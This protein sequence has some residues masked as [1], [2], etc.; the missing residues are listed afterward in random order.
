VSTHQS[1][2][3]IG[4]Q[5]P[6]RSEASVPPIV[7]E[8]GAAAQFAWDEYFRG[9]I[10][11]DYTR[12]TYMRAVKQ[13]LNWCEIQRFPLSKITPGMV[14]EYLRGLRLATASKK[15]HLA[16]IRAFFDV[17]VQRH[18]IALNPAHSVRTERL[19]IEEGRTPQI[20]FDE[21]ITLL[22]SIKLE[23]VGDFRDRAVIATLLFTAARAGAVAKLSLNDLSHDRSQFVLTFQEKRGKLRQIPV[24]SELDNYLL[25]YLAVAGLK[26]GGGEAPF[27][28]TLSPD[29]NVLLSAR[30]TAVDICRMVKRRLSAAGLSQNISPHSFRSC[31]ATTLLQKN[32]PLADVQ[33][34]LG[35]ADA[36]TTR[37]Y[38][39]RQK[40]VTRNIVE[41]ISI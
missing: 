33:Y 10:A 3:P 8:A 13:F 7:Q 6:D 21:A 23:T 12:Q 5:L 26:E 20:T 34:L 39:R 40:Q 29:G 19:Q 18:A 17:L 9:Q 37:L 28:R 31:A 41:Q 1:L 38:D 30:M 15:V 24:R 36:R 27:F 4:R 16:A 14:G 32:V 11:N 25:E 2:V 22:A 35:H